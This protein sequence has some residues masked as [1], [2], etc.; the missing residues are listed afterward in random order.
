M[1]A[2]ISATVLRLSLASAW[3]IATLMLLSCTAVRPASPDHMNP[4]AAAYAEAFG[5]SIDEASRRLA[6]QAQI[7]PLRDALRDAAGLRWAAGW[8]EHEPVFRY[9]VTLKGEGRDLAALTVDWPLP[10][11]FIYGA[12]YTEDELVAAMIRISALL[13]DRLPSAGMMPDVRSGSIVVNGPD[14]PSDEFLGELH[15]IAG[16]PVRYEK[17]PPE[18]T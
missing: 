8:L 10:V 3:A 12:V 2:R 17:T 7:G 11:H 14:A 9:V 15:R 5:V 16:V 6:I 1:T 13:H 4:E 18:R